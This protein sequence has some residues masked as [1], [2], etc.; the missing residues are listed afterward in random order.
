MSAA[1]TTTRPA[2]PLHLAPKMAG[3]LLTAVVVWAL[4]DIDLKYSRL[5]ELPG[6]LARTA[7][8]MFVPPDWAY[9]ARAWEGM[10]ESIHIAWIGTLI[11]A[12]LSLPLGLFGAE[13]VATR[14]VAGPVR[15]LLN[16]IR[17]IPELVLALVIFIPVVGLG[18][19]AGTL[20]IGIHSIGTLGKLMAEVI[21][22]IDEG[23]VEAA[24]AA[25]AGTLNTF[26]WGVLPQVMPEV[27]AF[28]FYRFEINLRASAILGL[29]GAGG[30]GAILSN[31]LT[32]RR[33]DKAGMTVL[34]VLIATIAIDA[35]SGALRRRIIRGGATVEAEALTPAPDIAA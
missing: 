11:G 32:F 12:L 14:T 8:L 21:E 6:R 35:L 28:W 27:V 20:A 15:L 23:P 22:G 3:F 24:R 33:W 17:A 5:I 1:T 13:N 4:V 9:A 2:A 16:A 31:T 18:A 29:V 26:R 34:V 7:N 10:L 30:V 25:G 19:F